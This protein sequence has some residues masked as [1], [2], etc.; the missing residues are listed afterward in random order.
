MTHRCPARRCPRE[1]PDHLLACG[2][3]WRLVPAPLARAVYAAYDH[4]DGIGTPE[5]TA[6][7]S[8][9]I[10]AM[11]RALGKTDAD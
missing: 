1:V 7:Q 10:R 11:N 4:G 8:A 5:L 3:H 2:T 9:A 6:A